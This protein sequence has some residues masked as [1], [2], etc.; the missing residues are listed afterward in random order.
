MAALF[1]FYGRRAAGGNVNI[2]DFDTPALIVSSASA[3]VAVVPA[4]RTRKRAYHHG[5]LRRALLD[6][7]LALA[8]ERGPA[9]LTLREAARRAGVTEAAPY[10]HFRSKEALVAALAEEGFAAL[11][12]R[13]RR[14]LA[15]APDQAAARLSALGV[16]YLRFAL[17]RPAHFRVMFGRDLARSHGFRTVGELAQ[18]CFGE[19]MREVSRAQ[20]AGAVAG[21]DPRPAALALWSALHGLASLQADGLLER[22]GLARGRGADALARGVV[23]S[24]WTGL[25]RR[26]GRQR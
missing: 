17:E 4:A 22:Q 14:A 8:A 9:A 16:A 13:V 19:L 1:G 3:T 6:Q 2:V 7:A 20:A 18:S 15:R 21:R 25:A 12:A 11:L 5:D 23:S 26:E 24:L 10:R